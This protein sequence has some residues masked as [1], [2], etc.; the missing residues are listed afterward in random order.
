M[1][2]EEDIKYTQYYNNKEYVFY[3]MASI[4]RT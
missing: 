3:K 2:T 4:L 1:R